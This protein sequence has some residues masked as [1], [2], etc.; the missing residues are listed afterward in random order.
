MSTDYSKYDASQTAPLLMVEQ[1]LIDRVCPEF[2]DWYS[3]CYNNV[4]CVSSKNKK[5]SFVVK[6]NRSSG[7]LF[8][9]LG[10]TLIN[11]LV[12]KFAGHKYGIDP[13]DYGLI[14]EGDDGLIG[15]SDSEFLKFISVVSSRLGL[16]MTYE[17]SETPVG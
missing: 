9:S 16:A 7:D 11:G 3:F 8:T 13:Y 1:L 14:C 6:K 2:S 17:I 5:M 15:S 12:I 10:N 4:I